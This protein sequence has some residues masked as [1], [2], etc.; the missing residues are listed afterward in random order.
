MTGSGLG[1]VDALLVPTPFQLQILRQ[2]AEG[3]TDLAA[4]RTLGVGERTIR[5]QIESLIDSLAVGNRA[6]LFVEVGRR[7]WLDLEFDDGIDPAIEDPATGPVA[8]MSG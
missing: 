3:K 6:A 5:R 8:A 4:A 2:K 1:M 7:G